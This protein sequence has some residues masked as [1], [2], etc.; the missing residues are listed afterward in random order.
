MQMKLAEWNRYKDMLSRIS[1]KAAAEFVEYFVNN[2]G[3]GAFKRSDIIK[4][5]HALITKYG[6]ASAECACQMYDAT[7]KW[8]GANVPEAM[9]AE[10]ATIE[11][12]GKAVNGS[13]KQ[14]PTGE[15]LEGVIQRL[16]KQAV[17]DTTLQNAL[18]DGAEFAWV[19]QGDTCMFCIT[20]ASRGWQFASKKL[21][22]GGHAEHIH[23]HCDC[24]F[25]IRFGD[26][27][28]EGYDP[29]KYLEL[30][31]SAE[32]PTAQDRVNYLRRQHYQMNKEKINAQKRA[33]YA[34]KKSNE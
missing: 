32:G 15:L 19:P 24:H 18:R 29:D 2:G 27:E 9:P 26:A 14:S 28:I 6:E 31:N 23:A 30:Y 1:K 12:V 34:A 25:A 11:E 20:L 7:A 8:Q 4:V 3:Y 10:V 17:E 16:I 33:N 13:L 22:K 21:I 5:A